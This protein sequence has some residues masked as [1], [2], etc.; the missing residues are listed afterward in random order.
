MGKIRKSISVLLCML[1]ACVSSNVFAAQTGRFLESVEMGEGQ[2]K[3]YCADFPEE[4]QIL[5]E[6]FSVTL[7]SRETPVTDISTAEKEGAPVTAYCLVDVSGSMHEEQMAQAKDILSSVCNGLKEGDNMVIASL[8]NDLS[9]SDFLT[10]KNEILAIIEGLSAGHEDTNLYKGIVNS[11]KT[12]K[13]SGK[14][15]RKKC[16]LILS[17]GKDD[18]K[19]GITQSEAEAAI[20]DSS[21]P[22]YTAAML[23]SSQSEEE[24]ASAKLLGSFARMSAGGRDYAPALDGS[25]AASV[26]ESIQNSLRNGIVLTLDTSKAAPD[27]KDTLLLR[28]VYTS[29]DQSVREDTMEVFAEDLL[30]SENGTEAV[31]TESLGETEATEESD[32][33]TKEPGNLWER[34]QKNWPVAAGIAFAV[35]AAI[36][37]VTIVVLKRKKKGQGQEIT[38]GEEET[39]ETRAEEEERAQK[40]APEVSGSFRERPGERPAMREVRFKAIGYEDICFALRMEEDRVMTIGRDKRADLILNPQDRRLSGIHCKAQCHGNTLRIWDMDSTNGTFVNGVSLKKIGTA[41]I[42]EG[43]SVRMGSYEYRITISDKGV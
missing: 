4:K 35:L 38:S 22:V 5:P 15:N 24:I 41:V 43:Q 40:T 16:L 36:V 34:L 29:Q 25:D 39:E 23:K 30:F 7:G 17:D 42:E 6:Q 28:V 13:E 3:L 11:M 2:I 26:G 31:G 32:V 14:A 10:D 37:I 20:R 8:G 33:V 9:A 18:Q 21:I 12:L 27:N 19:S 1:F